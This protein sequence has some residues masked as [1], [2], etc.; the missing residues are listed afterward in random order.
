MLATPSWPSCRSASQNIKDGSRV[1]CWLFGTS[2]RQPETKRCCRK[3]MAKCAA[4]CVRG[5]R[6]SCTGYFAYPTG[7]ATSERKGGERPEKLA[8]TA[9]MWLPERKRV[10]KGGEEDDR[11]CHSHPGGPDE[12]AQHAVLVWGGGCGGACA[13]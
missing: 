12:L 2:V 4:F 6:W 9:E 10:R 8:K 7:Y 3:W 1:L 13:P 11:S 5:P